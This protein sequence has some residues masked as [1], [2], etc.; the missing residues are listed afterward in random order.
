M[1]SNE[2]DLFEEVLF[3]RKISNAEKIHMRRLSNETVTRVSL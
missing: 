3:K 2:K 1:I